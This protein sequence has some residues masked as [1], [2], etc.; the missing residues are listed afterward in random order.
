MFYI[1]DF[2]THTFAS[3]EYDDSVKRALMNY[4]NRGVDLNEFEVVFAESPDTRWS[5][6][7]FIDR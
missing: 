5:G 3:C 6:S 2:R 7:E 1:L 4:K